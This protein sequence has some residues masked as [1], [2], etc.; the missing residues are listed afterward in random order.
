MRFE[1]NRFGLKGEELLAGIKNI[2]KLKLHKI[3][4]NEKNI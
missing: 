4:L 3:I 2:L 1:Q